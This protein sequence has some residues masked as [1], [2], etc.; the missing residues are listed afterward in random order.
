M[1][2]L[3]YT[4]CMKGICAHI[5]IQDCYNVVTKEAIHQHLYIHALPYVHV[6]RCISVYVSIRT[7]I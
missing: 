5:C 4:G 3:A 6:E 7:S 2:A 1:L